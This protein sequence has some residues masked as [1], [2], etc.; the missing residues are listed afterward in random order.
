MSGRWVL[1]GFGLLL[2]LGLI[3]CDNMRQQPYYRP[4]SASRL[5][6]DGTSY[7]APPENTV[8]RGFL[9]EDQHFYAGIENGQV[10]TT[11]P[12]EIDKAVLVRGQ[13]RYNAFCSPCHGLLGDGNGMIVQRGYAR[14]PPSFH[15]ERLRTA[16]PG[17]F[18]DVI[19]NGFGV[20][21]DY[22]DRIPPE[23]RWAIV[24]YIRALQLSQ[25]ATLA[26]VPPD[27]VAEL[28]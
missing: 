7:Q 14:R 5:F 3:G 21:Y 20:M 22:S 13:E 1:G 10:A 17:H 11:F 15:E 2:F 24:A 18:F 23:D 4:Y 27:K 12:I 9:R 28:R 19:T 16:P 6:E 8:A 26:E 25:N